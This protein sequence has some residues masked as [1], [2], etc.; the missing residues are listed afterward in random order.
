MS[1]YLVC[2]YF[3]FRQLCYYAFVGGIISGCAQN[4]N[5]KVDEQADLKNMEAAKQSIQEN[6]FEKKSI[7]IDIPT[8]LRKLSTVE[9]TKKYPGKNRPDLGYGNEDG[10][11]SVG[12]SITSKELGEDELESFIKSTKL[13]LFVNK[14]VEW[15]SDSIETINGYKY[16]VLKFWSH[17]IDG[18]V[19]NILCAGSI[20][21][22]LAMMTFNCLD[23]EYS[24]W[25]DDLHRVL[26]SV[27]FYI[28]K[29]L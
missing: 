24:S 26:Y 17:S 21:G 18:D 2:V 20:D 1:G 6:R 12:I 3:R 9:L 23:S 4:E 19:F 7:Q 16:A 13:S 8:E 11:V 29:A 5:K 15:I 22:K 10:S 25:N 14:E 27:N 28:P